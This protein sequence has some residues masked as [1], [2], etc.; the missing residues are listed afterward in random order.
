[1]SHLKGFQV[2]LRQG[3]PTIS[4]LRSM[5]PLIRFKTVFM[6]M[7]LLPRTSWILWTLQQNEI[8]AILWANY[9]K[10]KMQSRRVLLKSVPKVQLTFFIKI[11]LNV[12]RLPFYITESWCKSTINL[13]L[14]NITQW[15][16][17]Y[18]QLKLRWTRTGSQGIILVIM[19]SP[20]TTSVSP[21][22]IPLTKNWINIDQLLALWSPRQAKIHRSRH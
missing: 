8:P 9:L 12:N 4:F 3:P 2:F 5:R 21:I 18:T 6:S 19:E 13:Q 22:S 20:A 17:R 10:Y 15:I 7:N 16:T 14:H 1:M 11:V